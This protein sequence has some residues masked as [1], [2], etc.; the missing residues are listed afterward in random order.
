MNIKVNASSEYEILMDEGLLKRAGKEISR[1]HGSPARLCV[2]CDSNIYLLYGRENLSFHKSLSEAGFNVCT[3]VFPGGEEFKTIDTVQG[4]L[5]FLSE[6]NF[7]RTDGIVALGGGITGDVAG[8]AASIFMRGISCI[9]V[10]TSLLAMADSSVGGKTGVNTAAGKNMTGS[11]WQPELVLIDP[12]ALETLP[13]KHLLEGLAEIIKAAFIGDLSIIDCLSDSIFAATAKAIMVKKNL[14]EADEL[15][16]GERK[17]L[18]LGHTIAHAIEKCSGYKISHGSA[19]MTGMYLTA[20]AAD[21]LGWSTQP[22]APYIKKI[23]DAFGYKVITDFAAE[24]L[25]AAALNDKKRAGDNITI[26]YPDV[27][28][29]CEMKILPSENLADFIDTGLKK[30][31]V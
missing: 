31:R 19:V 9:Q 22:M 21:K 25:A 12:K 7:T 1:V 2:V 27:P 26:V 5:D 3:Y 30:A 16:S 28:G 24:D 11:F 20:L 13:E 6:N 17:L 23:I 4:I 15:E 14:V 29:H 10:P 8:F 18:N